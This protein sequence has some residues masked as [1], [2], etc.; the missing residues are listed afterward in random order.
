[1]PKGAWLLPDNLIPTEYRCVQIMVPDEPQYVSAFWGALHSLTMWFN[2][3]RDDG[4]SGKIVGD[5]WREV[6]QTAN[7]LWQTA[8]PCGG[9]SMF[10]DIRSDGC[11][12]E[13]QRTEGGAWELLADF[14]SCGAVGPAGPPGPVG[15]PGECDCT[16]DQNDVSNEP[17]ITIPPAQGDPSCAVA[18]N[19]SKYLL[20]RYKLSVQEVDSSQAIGAI[21]LTIGSTLLLG[22]IGLIAGTLGL[23]LAY[24]EN[25]N[26]ATLLGQL[27]GSYYT[28]LID[29][30][31]CCALGTFP[32]NYKID[33]AWREQ[34]ISCI[35][36]SSNNV[37]ATDELLGNL[38][39]S[40]SLKEL[41]Q[42]MQ[43]SMFDYDE[44]CNC[45]GWC[46]EFDFTESFGTQWYIADV[47]TTENPQGVYTP[48][49]G[50]VGEITPSALGNSKGIKMW[51]NIGSGGAAITRVWARYTGVAG[52]YDVGWGDGGIKLYSD[53]YGNGTEQY[54]HYDT[55]IPLPSV[56]H[57]F[58]GSVVKSISIWLWCSAGELPFTPDG[59][60]TLESVT[61]C[62][63]GTDP[64]AGE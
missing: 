23:T 34:W 42:Y 60:L 17:D 26:T 53:T 1:M 55:P 21:L 46:H 63:T 32:D 36:G 7:D 41:Y 62:G 57:Q 8:D 31:A 44:V 16:N 64:F 27:A 5:V 48:G 50:I 13:V 14:S 56:W 19:I 11:S 52:T 40:I 45:P 43:V 54:W 4:H 58:N 6:I 29:I 47:G 59:E 33:V 37:N 49:V 39:R 2:W 61:I 20:Y 35:V 30:M 3:E 28:D 51:R 25:L 22:P 10:Y 15:P 18:R 24:I 9:N 38:I 12:I